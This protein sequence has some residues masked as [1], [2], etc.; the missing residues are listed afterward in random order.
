MNP[1]CQV[2][3]SKLDFQHI[4]S[5]KEFGLRIVSGR[6]EKIKASGGFDTGCSAVWL[7]HL[8]WDQRVVGSNPITPIFG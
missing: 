5:G 1:G 6:S 7:A 8:V 2:E 4:G 3:S